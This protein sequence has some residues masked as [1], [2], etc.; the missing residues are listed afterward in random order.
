MTYR[1][2]YEKVVGNRRMIGD[3]WHADFHV[4]ATQTQTDPSRTQQQQQQPQQQGGSAFDMRQMLGVSD[5]Q[6]ENDSSPSDPDSNDETNPYRF[7][8]QQKKRRRYLN[9]MIRGLP[10]RS[11]N[12][13]ERENTE[14]K[15]EV[16][17]WKRM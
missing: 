1:P 12:A 8:N 4:G 10:G 2:G 16:N 6:K 14:L 13:T 17:Y 3:E 15:S 9:E 7:L 11:H 5:D